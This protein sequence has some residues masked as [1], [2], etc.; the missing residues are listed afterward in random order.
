[1]LTVHKKIVTDEAMQPV[2]VLIDY[3]DWL[4]IERQLH[5]LA[6][7]DKQARITRMQERAKRYIPLGR[8]LS[9][10]LLAER[11]AEAKYE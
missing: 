4:E 2:A 10:E 8:N 6:L 1:M 7:G 3:Q 9:E 5:L 11:R